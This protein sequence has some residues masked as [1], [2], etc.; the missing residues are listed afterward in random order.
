[1]ERSIDVAMASP[2]NL[3]SPHGPNDV[4]PGKADLARITYT[5]T[6]SKHGSAISPA[7]LNNEN[8]NGDRRA[9][10]RGDRFEWQW[11]GNQK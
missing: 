9:R 3:D 5:P 8:Y 11:R 1:M 4:A 10:L 7:L 2:V 6:R